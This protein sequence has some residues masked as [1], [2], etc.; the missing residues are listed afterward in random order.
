[1]RFLRERKENKMNERL[2]ERIRE[3]NR[4][5]EMAERDGYTVADGYVWE[6][7]GNPTGPCARKVCKVEDYEQSR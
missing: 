6:G 1:M 4:R 2:K 3:F 5:A 7:W